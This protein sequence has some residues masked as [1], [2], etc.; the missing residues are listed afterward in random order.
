MTDDRKSWKLLSRIG[1]LEGIRRKVQRDS[2]RNEAVVRGRRG[3]GSRLGALVTATAS[4]NFY[5]LPAPCESSGISP[6]W[7]V[8]SFSACRLTHWLL[9]W[10]T[11]WVATYKFTANAGL[12]APAYHGLHWEVGCKP[13]SLDKQLL[14]PMNRESISFWRYLLLPK[15]SKFP[16]LL[17]ILAR[18]RQALG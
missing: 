15:W 12:L 5:P 13:Q 8:P 16:N 4:L 3:W 10:R 14:S 9:R 6:S 18:A 1:K 7:S 2:R 11:W 17:P